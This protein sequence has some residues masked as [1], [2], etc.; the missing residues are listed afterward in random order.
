MKK[1][2]ILSLI[3]SVMSACKNDD[4]K[5]PDSPNSTVYFPYQYP[6]RTITL[7][8]DIFDTSLDN[9]HKCKIMATWG[10]GYSNNQDVAI[11][12]E[13]DPG[14]AANL[15]YKDIGSEVKIMPAGYYI[16]TASKINIPKGEISG[17]VEVTLTDAF[18][19]DPLALKRNYVIPLVM[20][21]VTN[22]GGILRGKSQLPD[23][24]RVIASDWSVVP[25]DYVLYAIK[26]I[27]QW[28]ANY[29]RRGVDLITTGNVTEKVSRRQKYVESD[30]IKKLSTLSLSTLQMPVTF[31]DASGT[32]IPVLLTLAF[33]N[34][35]KCTI[36][37]GT[38]SI[39]ATGTGQFV[40]KGEK[41]SWGDKDRDA[42][43]LDYNVTVGA[44]L[45]STKD[46]LVLRDRGVAKET[47]EV[48]PK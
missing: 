33:D 19:A 16:L 40:K 34:T 9:A 30:E 22:A 12:F 27:N 1:L 20:K 44:K 39:T 21:N 13:V 32:N 29:L 11:D 15:K 45:Y 2:I 35:G 38:A 14:I 8:E 17:G 37:S 10:G 47:F 5:F 46:T 41:K 36:A 42:L 4:W 28:D 25:K 18:F 6:V 23:P 26:Y 3:I 24:K 43:Y 48:V 31:K 7:G